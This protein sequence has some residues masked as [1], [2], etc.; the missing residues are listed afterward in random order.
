M[1]CVWKKVRS[2]KHTCACACVRACVERFRVVNSL[3]FFF[4]CVR[5][6]EKGS[7]LKLTLGVGLRIDRKYE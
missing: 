7:T 4:V 2:G 1:F 3:V 6:V 5:M